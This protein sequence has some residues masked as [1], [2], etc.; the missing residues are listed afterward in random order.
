MRSARPT[1]GKREPPDKTSGGPEAVCASTHRKKTRNREAA[2][3][4][5][6][7]DYSRLL[8]VLEERFGKQKHRVRV[9]EITGYGRSTIN[10]WIARGE[11]MASTAIIRLSRAMGWNAEQTAY[12][13]LDGPAPRERD[14]RAEA[15]AQAILAYLPEQGE[16]KNVAS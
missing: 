14:T 8:P 11:P 6:Q 15:L 16:M 4:T 13:M 1:R 3:A 10:G 7:I 12:Y 2:Y 9:A 5:P